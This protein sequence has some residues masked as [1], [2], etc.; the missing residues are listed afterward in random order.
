VAGPSW[1]DES[2]EDS[3]VST[4][5]Y[6]AAGILMLGQMCLATTEETGDKL[7]GMNQNCCGYRR[8]NDN[9]DEDD[10]DAGAAT[11]EPSRWPPRI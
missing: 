3:L 10:E 8:P 2:L 6:L 7:N 4:R 9:D 11:A 5:L 1:I